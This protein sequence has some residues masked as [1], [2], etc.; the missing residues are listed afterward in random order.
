MKTVNNKQE[1]FERYILGLTAIVVGFTIAIISILGPLGLDI[2]KYASS[3]SAITQGMG[4]DLVNLVLVTPICIIGGFLYISKR[5][6]AKYFLILVP[7]YSILYTGLAYGLF[8]EWSH[9]IYTGNSEQFS[10]LFY[11]VII[12]SLLLLISTLSMFSPEDAPDFNKR[13]LSIYI[14]LMTIFLVI[15]AFMWIGEYLEVL[16]TGDTSTGSYSEAPTIFWVIRYFDLGITIPLGFIGL[17]LLYTRTKQA[18]PIMLLFFGF[19]V[20]ISTAVVGMAVVMLLTN[21]PNFQPEGLLI[22]PVLAFLAWTGFFYLIKS[23]L[24]LFNEG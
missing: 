5:D 11:I 13:N 8:P 15:F 17:Y 7:L 12:G 19:F 21:D 18:Y 3:E 2:I 4:Q 20:T 10:I 24:P 1:I 6:N 23:K 22:F 14:I 16:T 9:P